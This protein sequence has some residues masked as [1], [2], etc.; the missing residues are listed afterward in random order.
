MGRL[1]RRL[2]RRGRRGAS[3]YAKPVLAAVPPERLVR[4]FE[5]WCGA[6]ARD[7]DAF[8][9]VAR[10]QPGCNLVLSLKK[11]GVWLVIRSVRWRVVWARLLRHRPTYRFWRPKVFSDGE[12]FFVGRAALCWNGLQLAER[13]RYSLHL[14]ENQ[15]CR[16]KL[17]GTDLHRI[18]ISGG[19]SRRVLFC[20]SQSHRVA[21]RFG[22]LRPL[23]MRNPACPGQD[24]GLYDI[25]D[26][27]NPRV[28]RSTPSAYSRR[29]N[30]T[31]IRA[32]DTAW[33]RATAARHQFATSIRATRHKHARIV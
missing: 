32:T 14:C 25:E 10:P 6:L 12:F 13:R 8:D 5:R 17:C 33:W 30:D 18:A 3:R 20:C 2:R 23:A 4:G 7:P 22:G 15:H 19:Q 9:R 29:T 24:V 16:V 28:P 21:A 31:M 27:L 26:V 11:T 1:R